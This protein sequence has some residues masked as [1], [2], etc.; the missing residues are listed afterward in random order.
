MANKQDTLNLLI[1]N[2]IRG[3]VEQKIDEM[4]NDPEEYLFSLNNIDIEKTD[5]VILSFIYGYIVKD[6]QEKIE[7]DLQ[8]LITTEDLD[9]DINDESLTQTAKS[10]NNRKNN[11]INSFNEELN[12]NEKISG[13]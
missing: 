2:I 8:Q 13:K 10:I 1:K 5:E 7:T 6:Q 11:I 9:Y 4:I 12:K 3:Y